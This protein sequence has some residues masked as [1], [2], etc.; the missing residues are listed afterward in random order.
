MRTTIVSTAELGA[1]SDWR[2]FDCRYDLGDAERGPR[3]YAEAHIAGAL[4]AHLER[5]LSGPKTGRNGRHPLPDA[6]AFAD[7]V[8]TQGITPSDQVVA[9]DNAGSS[10]A[11]RLWWMLQW[12]AH[13]AVAV[14]DGGFEKWVRE[15]RPVTTH[16]P[17]YPRTEYSFSLDDS[18]RVDVDLVE[19]NL[20]TR[21]SLVL[22]ARSASRFAG[23][24]ETLDPVAGHI[25]GARNRPYADNLDADQC[26]KPAHQLRRDF[27]A[28]LGSISAS[29]VISQCGSGVTAC[30]N[31]LA[32]RIAGLAGARLYPG[33]WSEWCSD[34]ARP[35]ATGSDATVNAP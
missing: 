30:H 31:I 26:F 35:I 27:E 18:M 4:Y 1:H 12:I 34:R 3:A 24:G 29:V 16:V 22:D 20:R 2:V 5:D 14:L 32:M 19:R 25:P 6:Q 9:Y 15:G 11:A 21:E 7:W 17:T 10:Y 13:R 8:G 23:I 33:S 28:L